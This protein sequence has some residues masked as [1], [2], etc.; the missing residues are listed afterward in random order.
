MR[1]PSILPSYF[2]KWNSRSNNNKNLEE[3]HWHIL[4]YCFLFP[5]FLLVSCV[6]TIINTIS[7][8][9]C[10]HHVGPNNP[11]TFGAELTSLS[12]G[13]SRSSMPLSSVMSDSL[14]AS[15]SS[16]F[17]FGLF[18]SPFQSSQLSVCE[19]L[20]S[21][22]SPALW[23]GCRSICFIQWTFNTPVPTQGRSFADKAGANGD[24]SDNLQAATT[25]C[26]KINQD[27]LKISSISEKYSMAVI[28]MFGVRDSFCVAHTFWL[29]CHISKTLWTLASLCNFHSSPLS[30]FPS[31]FLYSWCSMLGQRLPMS[32]YWL[33]QT[34]SQRLFHA[35]S[36][37]WD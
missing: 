35:G 14:L 31:H 19:N 4:S 10:D 28:S 36:L 23:A 16:S 32:H 30:S 15:Q 9:V 8:F 22:W 12:C 21:A 3:I 1:L 18:K 2:S 11:G 26:W 13:V 29:P 6:W 24:L 37:L 17:S 7:A 27:A 25:S 34:A 33:E 5:L 20:S